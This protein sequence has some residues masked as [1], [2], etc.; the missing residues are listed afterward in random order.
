MLI[1]KLLTLCLAEYIIDFR[2]LQV[3]IRIDEALSSVEEPEVLTAIL[4]ETGAFHKKIPGFK[5]E[6]FWVSKGNDPQ[7]LFFPAL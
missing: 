4:L 7:T 1:A 6:M 5:P 3:F 2:L